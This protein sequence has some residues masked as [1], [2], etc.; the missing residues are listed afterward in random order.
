MCERLPLLETVIVHG[1]CVHYW[2]KRFVVTMRVC[3]QRPKLCIVF[4]NDLAEYL[5]EALIIPND[6]HELREE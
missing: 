4:V 6:T 2:W 3:F 1:R 5:S